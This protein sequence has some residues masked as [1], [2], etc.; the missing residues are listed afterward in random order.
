MVTNEDLAK[1]KQIAKWLGW[2]SLEQNY[3]D[4]SFTGYRPTKFEGVVPWHWD[5]VPCFTT[6]DPAAIE[7]LPELVARG[8]TP[9][10][11][12]NGTTGWSLNIWHADRHEW[13]VPN[14]HGVTIADAI[15]KAVL[16]IVE[17]EN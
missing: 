1:N 3:A 2:T 17:E 5:T 9:V 6:S 7:L 12:S 16:I 4:E 15:T 14:L 11:Q 8:F 13:V 10:L